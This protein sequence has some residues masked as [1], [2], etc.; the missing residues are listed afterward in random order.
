[1]SCFLRVLEAWQQSRWVFGQVS[2]E[3]TPEEDASSVLMA[4]LNDEIEGIALQLNYH[5]IHHR[6]KIQT[7]IRDQSLEPDFVD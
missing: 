4:R 2:G 7:M 1:M 6:A 3:E 5:S